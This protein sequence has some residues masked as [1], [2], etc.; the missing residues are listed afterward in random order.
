MESVSRSLTINY[1]QGKTYMTASGGCQLDYNIIHNS[2]LG[3]PI[4]GGDGYGTLKA[5]AME[6]L[7]PNATA[8]PT[9]VY[10]VAKLQ[11][12]SN[13]GNTIS[14]QF[15]GTTVATNTAPSSETQKTYS[16]NANA[17][18]N[19]TR[20]S[21]IRFF[22]DKSSSLAWCDLRNTTIT[23]YFNRY[24]FTANG[25]NCS[26]SV[27]S[28]TGYDGDTVTFTAVPNSA[29][30]FLGW[31]NGDTR[32]TT[33][34]TYTHTVAGADLT[35]TAKATAAPKR[36]RYLLCGN[37]IKLGDEISENI[38]VTYGS[39][40]LVE[41]LNGSKTLLCK[42]KYMADKVY[43]GTRSAN[44]ADS[45]MPYHLV[46]MLCYGDW[47]PD[48]VLHGGAVGYVPYSGW[49]V[50]PF[51]PVPDGCTNITIEAGGTH[52]NSILHEFDGEFG[53]LSYW[54][55]SANPRTFSFDYPAQIKYVRASF[56]TADIQN[57]Y[58]KDNTHD[59]Y[60]F[61]GGNV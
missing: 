16:S 10:A 13:S 54:G 50:T 30:T 9:S 51:L 7:Y 35:L 55:G 33:G 22:T 39:R 23:L 56:H 8:K 41:N 12:G 4:T 25:E 42:S 37:S 26:V 24:D 46:A 5:N 36:K 29:C 17:V 32:L 57:C 38:S 1:G 21:T 48:T 58:I 14:L 43:V 2:A 47:M 19:S 45:I 18:K 34:R 31:Y 20:N 49:C 40:M 52:S 28:S 11:S 61:R 27:S 60:I 44:C 6:A 53:Y 59:I 15:D 3:N